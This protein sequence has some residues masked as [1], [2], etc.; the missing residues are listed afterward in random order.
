M[1]AY[2]LGTL[3]KL[4]A[5][6]FGAASMSALS[7]TTALGRRLGAAAGAVVLFFCRLQPSTGRA[8]CGA[9]ATTL[10]LL[11]SLCHASG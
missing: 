9:D 5:P 1:L 2:G 4:L 7:P 11:A 3:S 8:T 6:E 10:T